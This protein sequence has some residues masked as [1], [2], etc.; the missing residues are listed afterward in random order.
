MEE[1]KSVIFED[2]KNKFGDDKANEVL[3]KWD[4]YCKGAKATFE[5]KKL[6][7]LMEEAITENLTSLLDVM[8]RGDHF[9]NK[10]SYYRA[11]RKGNLV[12]D[13]EKT[14]EEFRTNIDYNDFKKASISNPRDLAEI[15]AY[16]DT[17]TGEQMSHIVSTYS[18]EEL[19]EVVF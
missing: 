8:T 16:I 4:Y 1:M 2:I 15:L 3:E 10:N 13:D 11:D 5:A 19:R 17:S 7:E 6:S 12:F 18:I 14:K 9:N